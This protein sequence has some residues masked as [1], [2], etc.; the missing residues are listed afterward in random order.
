MHEYKWFQSNYTI[1]NDLHTDVNFVD[2]LHVL[3]KAFIA[4]TKG[5]ILEL[6]HF[7]CFFLIL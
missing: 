2:A 1:V 3:P 5:S 4:T 6:M 7:S